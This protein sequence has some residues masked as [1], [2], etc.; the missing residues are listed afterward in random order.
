MGRTNCPGLTAIHNDCRGDSGVYVDSEVRMSDLSMAGFLNKITDQVSGSMIIGTLFP[1]VLFLVML[2]LVVLPVTP[3]AHQ[4]A[5]LLKTPE[6]WTGIGAVA[7]ALVILLS[8]V[9][10]YQ[11]N[12]PLIRLYEGYPWRTSWVGQLLCWRQRKHWKHAWTMYSRVF[13]WADNINLER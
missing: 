9:L 11:L 13:N 8:T 4:Y 6:K 12:N 1:V 2:V 10:L 5:D 3:Y 7:A